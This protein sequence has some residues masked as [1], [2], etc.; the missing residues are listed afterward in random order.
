MNGKRFWQIV[1]PVKRQLSIIEKRVE[2]L[3]NQPKLP[4]VDKSM[5]W[6]TRAILLL[7]LV[8]VVFAYY[9][10]PNYPMFGYS[11]TPIKSQIYIDN[12]NELVRDTEY[13]IKFSKIQEM[14]QKDSLYHDIKIQM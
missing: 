4:N 9:D 6:L 13:I 8:L 3:E 1:M 2:S 5:N 7:T 11:V 14:T 10:I 12:G